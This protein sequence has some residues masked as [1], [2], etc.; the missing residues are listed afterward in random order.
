[1]RN[2]PAYTLIE[3]L[4]GLSIIGLIFSFGYVSFREF[5]RRQALIGVAKI[6]KAD[7]RLTQSRALAGQ[8]P[9]VCASALNGYSFTVTSQT[10]Y[11][12][13]ASCTGSVADKVVTLPGD[14]IFSAP[15]PQPVIFKVLGQGTN[16]ASGATV[17]LNLNQTTT[18]S[19]TS[20]TVSYGGEIN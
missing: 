11:E 8:K 15:L 9:E 7:L 16:I 10:S 17:S 1:M 5:S 3:I 14:I 2:S 19:T 13:K 12:I 18:G 6:V 4:V 20:V